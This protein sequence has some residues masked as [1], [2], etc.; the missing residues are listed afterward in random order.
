MDAG[1]AAAALVG[2]RSRWPAGAGLSVR[3]AA[4]PAGRA[5]R[6]AASLRACRA[7]G[8]GHELSRLRIGDLPGG[9]ERCPACGANVAPM[10]EGAL[11]PDPSAR[12]SGAAARDARPQEAREDLEGRGARAHARPQAPARGDGDLPLFRDGEDGEALDGEADVDDIAPE[13]PP[14]PPMRPKVVISERHRIDGHDGGLGP[15]LVA[16]RGRGGRVGSAPAAGRAAAAAGG[17]G[18]A[19]AELRLSV[20][21]ASAARSRRVERAVA[22]DEW[23]LGAERRA[24]RP[25][26]RPPT[27]ASARR[28]AAL[29]LALLTVLW[30][31]V[32]YFASRAAHVELSG[33]LAGLAL[34]RRLPRVPRPDLRR[35]TSRAPPGRPWARSPTGLRVVDAGGRPPGYLR[36]FVRAA[37]GSLGVLA[38]GAGAHPDA[39]RSGAPRASTTAWSGPASSS[40]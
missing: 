36:A 26:E 2:A 14:A 29:D 5:A 30:A 19:R 4:P 23:A 10:T 32:V 20:R 38:A 17:R 3:A 8:S 11:A 33:L 6:C 16:D 39:P 7:A 18:H 15:R 35:R 34:S 37:L 12:A 31:V 21:R 25:V 27:P 22:D 13:P 1:N 40:D 24:A 9:Q 28:A